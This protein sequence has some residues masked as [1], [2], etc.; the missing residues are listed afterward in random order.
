MNYSMN[1]LHL[2]LLQEERL[3][4]HIKYVVLNSPLS[5]LMFQAAA[6]SVT[7]TLADKF[8]CSTHFF[9]SVEIKPLALVFEGSSG[10]IFGLWL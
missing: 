6:I 9:K 4:Q 3:W 1:N 2:L 10:A 5:F 8:F 7:F